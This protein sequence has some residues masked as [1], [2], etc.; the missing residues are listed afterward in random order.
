MQIGK[1]SKSLLGSSYS[2]RWIWVVMAARIDFFIYV[3]NYFKKKRKVGILRQLLIIFS[4]F[5]LAS[6]GD[7][8]TTSSND[9]VSSSASSTT[10][11]D[12][13]EW[14]NMD[15]DQD[16]SVSPDEMKQHY[17]DEGVYK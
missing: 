11:Y 6:C 12:K 1:A 7:K 9:S 8:A 4:L 15:S 10:G 14:Q 17:K 3:E 16:G 2:G 13:I 5:I